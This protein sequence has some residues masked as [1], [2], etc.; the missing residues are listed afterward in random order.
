MLTGTTNL[1]ESGP[2]SNGNEV[3]T[4]NTCQ[5]S[6]DGEPTF[7]ICLLSLILGCSHITNFIPTPFLYGA[8]M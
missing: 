6:I 8:G 4:M 7:F 1:D 2:G 3:I 5:M